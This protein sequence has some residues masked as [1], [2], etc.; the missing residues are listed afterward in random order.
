MK[1]IRC[2]K[3]SYNTPKNGNAHCGVQHDYFRLGA[4][5]R[6]K[7]SNFFRNELGRRKKAIT[8]Q[9]HEISGVE[10]KNI[11]LINDCGI[12]CLISTII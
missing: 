9:N 4:V 12:K 2:L 10:Y 3:V 7:I 1:R 11:D 5:G 8:D 6:E